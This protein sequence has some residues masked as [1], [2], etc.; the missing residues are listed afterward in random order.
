MYCNIAD[1]SSSEIQE[2]KDFANWIVKVDD[3]I[4]GE[5]NDNEIDI[6]KFEVRR[7]IQEDHPTTEAKAYV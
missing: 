6:K 7:S 3:G 2:T 1:S 5:H 4:A